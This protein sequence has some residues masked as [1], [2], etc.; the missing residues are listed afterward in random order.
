MRTQSKSNQIAWSEGDQVSVGFS[1]LLWLIESVASCL[2]QA[3]SEVKQKQCN[4]GYSRHS[5]E[6]WS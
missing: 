3:Q 4:P 6:K 5:I 1:F 2:N